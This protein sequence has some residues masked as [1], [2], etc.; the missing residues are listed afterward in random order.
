MV[1]GQRATEIGDVIIARLLEPYKNIVRV[2]DYSILA[3]IDNMFTVGTINLYE[4]STTVSGF[5]TNFNLSAGDTIIVGNTIL[6]VAT[7][8]S[9]IHIELASPAPF[10]AQKAKFMLPVNEN[11]TLFTSTGILIMVKSFLN[12]LP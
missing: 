6:E 9:P 4:G 3:G 11:I 10:T 5:G 12:L 8:I 1:T 2:V 7:Q